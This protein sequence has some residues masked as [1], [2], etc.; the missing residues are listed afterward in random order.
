MSEALRESQGT[1]L[2]TEGT[3]HAF[4][5]CRGCLSDRFGRGPVTTKL[6]CGVWHVFTGGNRRQVEGALTSGVRRIHP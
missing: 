6:A 4:C 1:R 3:V 2:R 5:A